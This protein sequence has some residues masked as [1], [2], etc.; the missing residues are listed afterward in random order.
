MFQVAMFR[1]KYLSN[2]RSDW[3]EI[4]FFPQVIFP[5]ELDSVVK[6]SVGGAVTPEIRFLITGKYIEC[7]FLNFFYASEKLVNSCSI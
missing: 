3:H 6:S 5:I 2:R 1:W 4:F 7:Q